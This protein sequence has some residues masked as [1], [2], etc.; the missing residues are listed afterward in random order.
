MKIKDVRAGLSES[1]A[2]YMREHGFTDRKNGCNFT[3]DCKARI[4]IFKAQVY[5]TSG[6][7]FT[8][9]L[10]GVGFPVLNRLYNQILEP[11]E[12]LRINGYTFGFGIS[13]E[14]QNRG[15][16]IIENDADIT[17]V[18][19]RIKS[20]FQEIALPYYEKNQNLELAER[21]LNQRTPSEA[22]LPKSVYA[23]CIGLIAARLSGNPDFEALADFYYKYNST[24]QGKEIAAPILVVKEFFRN[25]DNGQG[26]IHRI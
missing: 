25:G 23:A 6:L 19:A 20:D 14:Y 3:K 21:S 5:G 2:P 9:P 4:A 22:Y 10:V 1:V 11:E 13:N 17:S 12:R 18:V 8:K 24:V 7:Y 15:A 26:V 16:Y